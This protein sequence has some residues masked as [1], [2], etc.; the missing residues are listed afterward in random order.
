MNKNLIKLII[1]SKPENTKR[2]TVFA[3][4]IWKMVGKKR[5]PFKFE[6]SHCRKNK[7]NSTKVA[8]EQNQMFTPSSLVEFRAAINKTI[9]SPPYSRSMN[10]VIDREFVTANEMFSARC[11]IYYKIHNKKHQ[12]KASIAKKDI[13]Y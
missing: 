12:D 11:K 6:R 13:I 8:T 4:Q 5:H 2:S 1:D 9:I 7:P 10:I 3:L